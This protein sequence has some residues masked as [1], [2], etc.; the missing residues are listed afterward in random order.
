MILLSVPYFHSSMLPCPDVQC[1]SRILLLRANPRAT[2]RRAKPIDK[3]VRRILKSVDLSCE[4]P[5]T[6]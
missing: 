4:E 2:D 5:E 1:R 3:Y 6:Q